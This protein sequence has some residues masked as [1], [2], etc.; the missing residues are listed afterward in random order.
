MKVGDPVALADLVEVAGDHPTAQVIRQATARI[1]AA[2]V[3]IVEE[4][5]GEPAPA[6]RFDPRQAGV[7]QIG[8]PR[9]QRPDD[10]RGTP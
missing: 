5:R 9:K 6:E 8:N 2:L 10:G 4:L 1:M 3:A 7:R